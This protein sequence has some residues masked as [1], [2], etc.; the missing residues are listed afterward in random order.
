MLNIKN[1]VFKKRPIKKLIKQYIGPYIIEE[2]ILANEVKLKLLVSMRI[3]LV[4]NIS[5]VMR[6]LDKEYAQKMKLSI[7]KL[8]NT[9]EEC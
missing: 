6:L 5:Q 8:Q 1:L 7:E 3:H 2:I 9:L 4:V